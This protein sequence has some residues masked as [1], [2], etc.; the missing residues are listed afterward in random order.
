MYFPSNLL[1]S[2]RKQ[3]MPP[4]EDRRCYVLA[5]GCHMYMAETPA[6]LISDVRVCTATETRKQR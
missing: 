2:A 1:R 4:V 5:H 3:K 6:Y